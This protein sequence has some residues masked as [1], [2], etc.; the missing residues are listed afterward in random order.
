MDDAHGA[1]AQFAQGV[2]TRDR[3]RVW[4]GSG[5]VGNLRQF[6]AGGIREQA[7][8]QDGVAGGDQITVLEVEAG[9]FLAVDEGAIAAAHI[10]DPAMRR[11]HFQQKMD[12]RKI[13]V[14]GRQAKMSVLGTTDEKSVV[15]GKGKHLTL[16]GALDDGEADVGMVSNTNRW[17]RGLVGTE[18]AQ[19]FARPGTLL[20]IAGND[21]RHRTI[22]DAA[23][24]DA[25]VAG[26][27]RGGLS[28]HGLQLVTIS[29]GRPRSTASARSPG[30]LSTNTPA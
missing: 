11:I 17:Q 27:V 16:V 23:R 13:L 28:L 25:V 4:V 24:I 18:A 9:A 22:G 20:S 15:A 14:L 26:H 1:A 21:R 12:A 10:D 6:P 29:S 3:L 19:R 30:R 5:V 8:A 7:D 2:I